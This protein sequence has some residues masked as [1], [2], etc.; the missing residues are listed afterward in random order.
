MVAAPHDANTTIRASTSSQRASS[1]D[2]RRTTA[3][4]TAT[5]SGTDNK[6]KNSQAASC[7]HQPTRQRARA[8]LC[9]LYSSRGQRGV[10]LF[11]LRLATTTTTIT[12]RIVD[13]DG[14]HPVGPSECRS[15]E[16][17]QKRAAPICR[18]A[19]R[20]PV[21]LVVFVLVARCGR[22]RLVWCR[23]LVVF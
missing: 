2:E 10:A 1:V 14:G 12:T 17:S 23:R 4:T 7:R 11:V 22:R 18:G 20:V 19:C 3:T 5:T 15:R 16:S 9:R 8:T 21:T 13:G 6:R